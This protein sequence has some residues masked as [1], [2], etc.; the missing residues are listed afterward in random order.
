MPRILSIVCRRVKVNSTKTSVNFEQATRRR[1]PEGSTLHSHRR[2]FLGSH[3]IVINLQ[4]KEKIKK[5]MIRPAS[6]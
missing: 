6:I 4:F 2:E 3:N 5:N 1:I